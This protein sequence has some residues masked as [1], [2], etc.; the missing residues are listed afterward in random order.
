MFML[1]ILD[2]VGT[3]FL[4]STGGATGAGLTGLV[5]KGLEGCSSSRRG[6]FQTLKTVA[7]LSG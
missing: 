2:N 5:F 4:V 1:D 6:L 3:S 7:P